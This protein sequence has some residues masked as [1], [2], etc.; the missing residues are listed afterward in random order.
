[1][2]MLFSNPEVLSVKIASRSVADVFS[3]GLTIFGVL[4]A[5]NMFFMLLTNCSKIKKRKGKKT[6]GK[7]KKKHKKSHVPSTPHKKRKKDN[8]YSRFEPPKGPFR[9][10]PTGVGIATSP[11]KTAVPVEDKPEPT[12]LFTLK[13]KLVPEKKEEKKSSEKVES[14]NKEKPKGPKT[15]KE[16]IS[17]EVSKEKDP[18]KEKEAD[19]KKEEEEKKKAEEQ[20]QQEQKKDEA[21]DTKQSTTS[22]NTNSPAPE[23]ENTDDSDGL[24]ELMRKR[25]K[26]N[27]GTPSG[28]HQP[29]VNYPC[30]D[31]TPE[32]F[33]N[34][35]KIL[36]DN[37]RL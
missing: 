33:L 24:G 29:Q 20:K 5:I 14:E 12:Q 1:M 10:R 15:S 35:E 7:G 37:F 31:V 17:Q 6:R 23:N 18:E 26:A 27:A 3:Y 32:A 4:V 19:K 11:L 9:K 30:P 13:S 22:N 2:S 16:E 28:D 21:T 25:N 36:K 8:P 34:L